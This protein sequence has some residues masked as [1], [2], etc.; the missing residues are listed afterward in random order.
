MS[1]DAALVAAL[2]ATAMP[3]AHTAEDQ[4]ESWL[5]TM[6]LHGAVGESLRALGV[7]EKPLITNSDRS[8]DAVGTPIPE[9]DVVARVMKCAAEFV[10]ARGGDFVG[11]GDILF[12]LF[13]VYG[14]AMDRALYL[15][16]TSR[17]ELFDQLAL[18][19]YH[20]QV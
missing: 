6:R 14:Q 8:D 17:A 12:A 13:D 4:A 3:F 5:R 2:A 19:Q 1:Q 11:T 10:V 15:R 9:G 20:A 18:D 7:G 16:G